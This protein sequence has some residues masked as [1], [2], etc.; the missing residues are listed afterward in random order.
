MTN[1][2]NLRKMAEQQGIPSRTLEDVCETIKQAEMEGSG[3]EF[4]LLMSRHGRLTDEAR[5]YVA[6]YLESN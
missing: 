6:Q 2:D 4:A 5:A 3:R 1:G